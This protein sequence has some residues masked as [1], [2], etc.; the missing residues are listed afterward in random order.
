M[1]RIAMARRVAFRYLRANQK[2]TKVLFVEAVLDNPNDLIHWYEQLQAKDARLPDISTPDWEKVAHH[3]T[4]EFLGKTPEFKSK[5]GNAAAL[6]PFAAYLGKQVV[7]KIVGLTFDE[8]CVAV[9][10]EPPKDLKRLVKN[11]HPHITVAVANGQKPAY[12]NTLLETKGFERVEGAIQAR[13]GYNNG[14]QGVAGDVF[15][16]PHD[17]PA[18]MGHLTAEF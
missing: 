1:N 4:F 15:D 10:V 7:L 2:P 8:T 17:F 11:K 16:K 12:S 6:V 5:E 9:V 18:D 3:M 13:I 14:K